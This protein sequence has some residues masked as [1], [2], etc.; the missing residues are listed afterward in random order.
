MIRP[1][2]FWGRDKWLYNLILMMRGSAQETSIVRVNAT[3]AGGAKPSP[4]TASAFDYVMVDTTHGA[5]QIIIPT[6]AVGQ[7]VHVEQAD[8]VDSAFGADITV[9]FPAG[10]QGDQPPPSNGTFVGPFVFGPATTWTAPDALG[11]GITWQNAGT[12]GKYTIRSA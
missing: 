4:Y 8:D 6:L 7:W 1:P 11:M 5:C 10:V 3:G 12:A 9:T 2:N